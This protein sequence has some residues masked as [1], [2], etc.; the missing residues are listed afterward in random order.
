[1][2]FKPHQ[3]RYLSPVILLLAVGLKLPALATRLRNEAT[4]MSHNCGGGASIRERQGVLEIYDHE[5]A[6][7]KCAEEVRRF[8]REI[9]KHC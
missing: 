9:K 8:I 7:I 1:M 2:G 6:F 5:A 3:R 4:E